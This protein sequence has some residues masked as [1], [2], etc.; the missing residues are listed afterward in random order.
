MVVFEKTYNTPFF[1][2]KFSEEEDCDEI[3]IY[4]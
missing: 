4:L 1:F 2:D 3:D